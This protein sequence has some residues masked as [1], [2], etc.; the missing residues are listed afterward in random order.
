MI[1]AEYGARLHPETRTVPG[2]STAAM[3]AVLDAVA[4]SLREYEIGPHATVRLTRALQAV[5]P[6]LVADLLPGLD[7]EDDSLSAVAPE[8][9]ALAIADLAASVRGSAPPRSNLGS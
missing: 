2:M 8:D 4:V 3:L 7:D 1:N 5:D 9:L 6:R